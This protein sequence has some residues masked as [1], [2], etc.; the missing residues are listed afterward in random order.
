MK[1]KK[2][3][4]ISVAWLWISISFIISFYTQPPVQ[5]QPI[6]DEARIVAQTWLLTSCGL[7]NEIVLEDSL[8]KWGI[9]L[10]PFFIEAFEVG[11]DSTQLSEIERAAKLRFAERQRL[12]E[13]GQG[14]GLSE[15]NLAV[16]RQESIDQFIV[17]QKEDLILRY[18][19]QALAGL[20]IIGGD[21][22]KGL[23]QKIV[24]DQQSSLQTSAR[25]AL[26]KLEQK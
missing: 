13:T 19:S 15:E 8:T 7:R 12:L 21:K 11:P 1:L 18:R 14:L 16:A 20:S 4:R 22:A 3:N 2:R 25:Q 5:A 23:L 26:E 17:R 10:E 24:N 9:V 6:P